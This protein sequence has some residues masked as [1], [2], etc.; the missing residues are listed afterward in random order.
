MIKAPIKFLMVTDTPMIKINHKTKI[1]EPVLREVENFEHLF[2]KITWIGYD[3]TNTEK[4]FTS[5]LTNV[6]KINFILLPRTGGKGWKEKLRLIYKF[7]PYLLVIMKNIRT[8]DF[9]HSRGPSF[10]AFITIILSIFFKKK[11]FWHKYAGNWNQTNPPFSY[12]LQTI[13]LSSVVINNSIITINGKWPNQK[14]NILSFENPCLTETELE[15]ANYKFL[16]K[17]YKEKINFCF[18]GRIENSKGVGRVIK[19]FQSISDFSQIGHLY[20][21]GDGSEMSY[22][23]NQANKINHKKITFCGSLNRTDLNNIYK[24]CHAILL[25]TSASEGF[26]KV[27]AEAMAH[28]CVPIVSNIGCI[29]QYI[30]KRNGIILDQ[31]DAISTKESIKVVLLDR[32]ILKEKAI[33]G[34]TSAKLFSFELYNNKISKMIMHH[35][36]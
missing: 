16:K 33:F 28:G 9:I 18:V 27:L 21:V 2:S 14:R 12:Y 26:P 1:F 29:A 10:P 36:T 25:P 32:S 15:E 13:L 6:K 35:D 31:F 4:Y 24:E 7:I 20:F 11:N 34:I 17:D 23:K 3:F 8:H 5:R 30:D 22:F 19:A